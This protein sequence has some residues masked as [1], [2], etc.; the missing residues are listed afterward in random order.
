MRELDPLNTPFSQADCKD[1]S[2]CV[3]TFLE[4]YLKKGC[5][6]SASFERRAHAFRR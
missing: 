4:K 2:Y 5:F 3:A 6:F 1:Y